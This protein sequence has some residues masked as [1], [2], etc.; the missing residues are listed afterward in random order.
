M[1]SVLKV[2]LHKGVELAFPMTVSN[3]D[4][5]STVSIICMLSAGRDNEMAWIREAIKT[6][7]PDN[8]D[9]SCA[10]SS[11]TSCSPPK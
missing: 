10:K 3:G 5:V 1:M 9:I 7:R 4:S 8:F 2:S 11:K 6:H